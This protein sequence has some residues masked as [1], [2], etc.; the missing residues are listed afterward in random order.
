MARPIFT[1]HVDGALDKL[2]RHDSYSRFQPQGLRYVLVVIH[3]TER[4]ADGDEHQKEQAYDGHSGDESNA[5]AS[6]PLGREV[7]ELAREPNKH[8]DALDYERSKDH[9]PEARRSVAELLQQTVKI[10]IKADDNVAS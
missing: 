4:V 5:E 7:A 3:V 6:V 1:E 9:V 8:H 2:Q 10:T